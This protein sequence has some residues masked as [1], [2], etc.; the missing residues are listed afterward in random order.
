MLSEKF[1]K[2]NNKFWFRLFLRVGIIIVAFVLLLTLCNTAFLSS[3]YEYAHKKD[4]I[5]VSDD[6]KKTDLNN[7]AQMISVISTIEDEYGFEV[8]VYSNDG[9]IIYSSV[10]GQMMQFFFE[11]YILRAG[12]SG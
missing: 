2:L 12:T 3:Y 10:G 7:S 11:K 5:S 9:R 6:I 1:K 4:L 8:E